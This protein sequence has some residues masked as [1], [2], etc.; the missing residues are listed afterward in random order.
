ML[1]LYWN[2]NCPSS[3][4]FSAGSVVEFVLELLCGST[5]GAASP[6]VMQ[7]AAA[8]TASRARLVESCIVKLFR[9][10]LR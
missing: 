1:Q 5:T 8:S 4:P 3:L 6:H 2:A 7:A 9:S 10:V